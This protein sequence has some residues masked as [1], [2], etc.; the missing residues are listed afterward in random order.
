[1]SIA[2][3]AVAV[4]LGASGCGTPTAVGTAAPP[5]ELAK[6]SIRTN[7]AVLDTPFN[8]LFE[9][10]RELADE[11]DAYE[12]L[13]SRC[14]ARAGYPFVPGE[15]YHPTVMLFDFAMPF[16]PVAAGRAAR[17]GYH[18]PAFREGPQA[19]S[20]GG[21]PTPAW[22][23]GVQPGANPP[24]GSAGRVPAEG[25]HTAVIDRLG[26]P[27]PGDALAAADQARGAAVADP[28]WSSAVRAWVAC[29]HAKGFSYDAPLDPVD[30][31]ANRGGPPSR[32]ELRT[33]TEDVACKQSSGEIDTIVALLRSYEERAIET[34][35]EIFTRYSQWRSR[36]LHNVSAVLKTTPAPAQRYW[37]TP[38]GRQSQDPSI[39]GE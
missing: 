17:Y 1:M 16:G 11:R 31:Y 14:T 30:A 34:N 13:M 5:V 8:D 3:I 37:V 27:R 23:L 21:K 19:P 35:S 20:W 28:R 4:Q 39:L 26:G 6:A 38:D 2:A 10:Q 15:G 25:C 29:M 9:S 12:R 7:R 33:A 32:E 36:Y 22:V 18:D 24:P